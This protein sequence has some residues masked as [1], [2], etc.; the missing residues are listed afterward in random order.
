MHRV[1][2]RMFPSHQPAVVSLEVHTQSKALISRAR[3]RVHPDQAS[4]LH[5]AAAAEHKKVAL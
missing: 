1:K 2:V 5:T 3:F 4:P